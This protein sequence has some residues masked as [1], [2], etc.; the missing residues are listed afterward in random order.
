MVKESARSSARGR[1]SKDPYKLPDLDLAAVGDVKRIMRATNTVAAAVTSI[2]GA[3]V[4]GDWRVT[5]KKGEGGRGRRE[6]KGRK[7][8]GEE[9]KGRPSLPSME[10]EEEEGEGEGE[11]EGRCLKGEMDYVRGDTGFSPSWP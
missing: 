11:G 3:R 1:L 10:E 8:R 5:G 4:D 6:V 2:D 7:E 9:L